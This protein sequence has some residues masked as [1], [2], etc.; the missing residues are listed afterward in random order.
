[1][2]VTLDDTIKEGEHILV[3]KSKT[4]HSI[5]LQVSTILMTTHALA[6]YAKSHN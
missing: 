2:S 5:N 4:K 3:I 6:D 1:M